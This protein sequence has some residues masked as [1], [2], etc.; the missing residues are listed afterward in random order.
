METLPFNIRYQYALHTTSFE[1]QPFNDRTI[2]RFRAR[3]NAYEEMTGTDLIHYCML[4]PCSSMA[5]M[6]KL[7]TGMCR[8]DS[9]MVAS[10]IKKMNRLALLYT[11]AA[12]LAGRM[13]K[14]EDPALPEELVRYTQEDDHDRLF[15]ITAVKIPLQ[16]RTGI[17][18]CCAYPLILR[19][20]YEEYSEYQLLTCAIRE[21]KL[22]T[23]GQILSLAKMVQNCYDMRRGMNRKAAS[24]TKIRKDA[25]HHFR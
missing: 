13:K 22:A 17:K 12:N 25:K 5:T 11:S 20:P 19:E 1:E 18:G 9:L 6:V 3:C 21:Q 2:G 23:I 16:N 10:N 8:R 24:M 15:T 14:L 4:K 7:N